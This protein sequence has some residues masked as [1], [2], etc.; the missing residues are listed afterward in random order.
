MYNNNNT[1]S[2]ATTIYREAAAASTTPILSAT[3]S[4]SSSSSP[5]FDAEGLR[6][7]DPSLIT[8]CFGAEASTSLASPPAAAAATC[9]ADGTSPSVT[10]A[11]AASVAATS[12]ATWAGEGGPG[13]R[14]RPSASFRV[15]SSMPSMPFS[16]TI[17]PRIWPMMPS[18]SSSLMPSDLSTAA[19]KGSETSMESS[20]STG[21]ML[22]TRSVEVSRSRCSWFTARTKI[23]RSG[24]SVR[25]L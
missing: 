5:S 20:G 4:S 10:A 6:Y 14:C 13:S 15:S 16:S 3:A 19:P 7:S 18:T 25:R 1:P 22:F 17:S 2:A 9:A 24:N 12:A 23:G 8:T 11:A 21:T